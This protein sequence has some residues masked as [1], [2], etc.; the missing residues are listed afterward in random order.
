MRISGGLALTLLLCAATSFSAGCTDAIDSDDDY[1]ET[2]QDATLFANDKAAYDFFVAK[3][4][5][6]FQ[7]AGI[8][9]NLD[10]ESGVSPTSVQY[11]GGPGRGIAQ[12]SVGGRWDTS[13][14][15]VLHYA[16]TQ[17]VSATSLNLQLNFIW[18]ELTTV[19]YGYTQLKATTNV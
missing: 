18:Y 2:E 19:G 13:N 12:W 4:L 8:V 7:A 5:T 17:G 16:S 9:G 1:S 6:S 3:G 15:N 11:G 14:P 10:Q